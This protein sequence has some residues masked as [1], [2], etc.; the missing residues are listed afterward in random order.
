M[1]ATAQ[2]LNLAVRFA[3]ELVLLAAVATAAWHLPSAP[4]LRWITAATTVLAVA[5]AWVLVV[6]DDGL[7]AP[8]R[9]GAQAAALALGVGCLLWLDAPVLAAAV[10]VLALTNAAL[11]AAWDQ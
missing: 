5:T 8:V 7:A 1:L 9:V 2:L 11:L 6:H 3:V 10:T 4:A